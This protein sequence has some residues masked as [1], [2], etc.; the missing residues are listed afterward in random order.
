M[1]K[2]DKGIDINPANENQGK[3]NKRKVIFSSDSPKFDREIQDEKNKR[4]QA[5]PRRKR[6]AKRKKQRHIPPKPEGKKITNADLLMGLKKRQ[7]SKK[8]NPDNIEKVNWTLL[9]IGTD[10]L[11][12][13]KHFETQLEQVS[14]QVSQKEVD[15][16]IERFQRIFELKPTKIYRG[17]ET[18]SDYFAL[19]FNETDKV[20]LES[21]VYGNAIYIIEG[22]WRI[23]SRRTKA[24]LKKYPNTKVIP[25][26]HDWFSKLK[27]YTQIGFE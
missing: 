7:G 18:F 6:K 27:N 8:V 24:E 4:L 9:P 5:S 25:H 12:F 16:A 17:L 26:R 21:V 11:N 23:Q 14:S 22:D 3:L 15:E 13:K 10:W 19:L 1:K 2:K 20:V